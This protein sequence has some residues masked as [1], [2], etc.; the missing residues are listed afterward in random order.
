MG[1]PNQIVFHFTIDC[2]AFLS[3]TVVRT[4]S[5]N[6]HP[7]ISMPRIGEASSFDHT[8]LSGSYIRI[9]DAIPVR[10]SE[11]RQLRISTL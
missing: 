1:A 9:H 8:A 2:V 4:P 10:Q 7:S 3:E 6:L 5:P 11:M